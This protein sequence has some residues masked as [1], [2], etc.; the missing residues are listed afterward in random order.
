MDWEIWSGLASQM[1]FDQF[2]RFFEVFFLFVLSDLY[3][4]FSQC[5]VSQ[6]SEFK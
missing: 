6:L 1:I 4:N 3:L 5:F 2:I